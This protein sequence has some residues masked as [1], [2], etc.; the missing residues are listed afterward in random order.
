MFW[1][2]DT[3][4]A[5]RREPVKAAGLWPAVRRAGLACLRSGCLPVSAPN[6]SGQ[7]AG[8]DTPRPRP[9]PDRFAAVR[10]LVEPV[11]EFRDF[12]PAQQFSPDL[13]GWHVLR[14]PD[15]FKSEQELSAFTDDVLPPPCNKGRRAVGGV[16]SCL[17]AH[18]HGGGFGATAG[19]GGGLRGS[20]W[21][22][23]LMMR[24][25]EP[26]GQSLK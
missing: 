21:Y 16:Q 13:A 4:V 7:L 18:P 6:G 12:Q 17:L 22:H 14:T 9:P 24:L 25:I 20:G 10:G 23:Y 19:G 8:G 15:F 2:V 26:V 11:Q 3:L 1:R 5:G